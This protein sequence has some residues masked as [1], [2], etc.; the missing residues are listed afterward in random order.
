MVLEIRNLSVKIEGYEIVN[1]FSCQLAPGEKLFITWK[2][3][4]GKTTLFRSLLK[5]IP[6]SFDIFRVDGMDFQTI[7][8]SSLGSVMGFSFQSPK[9]Q[10][11][12]ISIKEE[13]RS[14]LPDETERKEFIKDFNFTPLLESNPYKLSQS[15][16]RILT[17]AC[18]YNE[19]KKL[20]LLDEPTSDL[21]PFTRQKIISK[22]K[23]HQKT[24]VVFTHDDVFKQLAPS[25]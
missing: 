4:G 9:T 17:L 5:I 12:K 8:K 11:T 20:L 23:N 19:Q 6:C 1:D 10:F 15:E 16:Q 7:N 3:G 18:L 24:I 21:D 25:S 2:T 13:L 22:I 14:I